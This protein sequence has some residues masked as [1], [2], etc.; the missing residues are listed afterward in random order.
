MKL[1]GIVTVGSY[2]SPWFAPGLASFYFC[3]EIIV[4]NGGYDLSNPKQEEYNVPLKQISRDIADLDVDGKIFEWTGWTVKDL[5]HDLVLSTEFQNRENTVPHWADMRGV[6]LTLA[7]E[8]AVER[9]ADMI[10][11]WDSDQVG[12]SD[13]IDLVRNMKP[14]NFHQTEL[15]GDYFLSDPPPASPY[16][17]SVY[18]F[19]AE[20]QAFFGGG[21]APAIT[22]SRMPTDKHHCLHLRS[23]NPP[24]LSY[25]EKFAH[26]YGRCW[27]RYWTNE[28]LWADALHERAVKSARDLFNVKHGPKLENLPLALKMNPVDYIKEVVKKT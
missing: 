3:D 24:E 6:G 5:K 21:G 15:V 13:C 1:T 25:E 23:A 19:I 17:D 27:F 9:G 26:F 10:L 7:L 8:K 14:V 28:G 16:N 2:Y 20:R 18:T 4:T 12:F 22:D 11:K